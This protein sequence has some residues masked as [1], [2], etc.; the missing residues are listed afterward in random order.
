M[1][2]E[3]T[4]REVRRRRGASALVR[5]IAPIKDKRPE[6]DFYRTPAV[7]VRSL[8]RVEPDLAGMRVWEPACG[9]GR[10]SRVLEGAGAVVTSTDL[11]DRGHGQSGVDF[12][13]HAP[14]HEF[15]AIVTNPP[16][17]HMLQFVERAVSFKPGKVCILGRLLVLENRRLSSVFKSSR[18]SRVWAF[19][20]RINVA[21]L[22]Y[23]P[24]SEFGGMIA[25]AWFVW[26]R[27]WQGGP[28][29]GWIDPKEGDN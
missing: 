12:L 23:E 9:D 11:A 20:R 16:F 26:E 28:T 3:P 13:T 22:R 29:V 19:T 25:F 1:T 18:L 4:E 27:G 2:T 24:K 21:P 14:L 15:D 5:G 10:I 8:V 7:A 6:L 17:T